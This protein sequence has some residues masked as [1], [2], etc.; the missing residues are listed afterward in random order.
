MGDNSDE[1]MCDICDYPL[2][3][4]FMP[5]YIISYAVLVAKTLD[6]NTRNG[7]QN[8]R[9]K[10]ASRRNGFVANFHHRRKSKSFVKTNAKKRQ[11]Q[12]LQIARMQFSLVRWH[13]CV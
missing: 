3:A 7:I 13:C 6:I 5:I 2:L 12:E 9:V 8:V 1:E 11:S 4:K 10:F